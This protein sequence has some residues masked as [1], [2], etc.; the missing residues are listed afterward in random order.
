LGSSVG[1]FELALQGCLNARSA[2]RSAKPA[3]T[4]ICIEPFLAASLDARAEEPAGRRYGGAVLGIL[5]MGEVGAAIARQARA[6]LGAAVLYYS[7]HPLHRDAC[8]RR[9]DLATL[10]SSADLVVLVLPVGSEASNWIGRREL[11][12]L[13]PEKLFVGRRRAPGIERALAFLSENYAERISVGE[14]A[15]KAGLSEFHFQHRFNSM[16]GI[17]PHR[18]QLMLRV[19]HAK[20]ILR[21]G[22]AIRDAATSV[23]FADQSHLHRYFRRIV[24]VTPGQY[25]RRVAHSSH[26]GRYRETGVVTRSIVQDIGGSGALA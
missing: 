17:T 13:A 2:L 21:R 10:F 16:L 19:F 6:T 20:S 14:L 8:A 25:Q 22:I 24:G 9:V 15:A 1:G 12:L 7:A 26:S 18:Y 5:G 3:A 4:E 11:E 23:G